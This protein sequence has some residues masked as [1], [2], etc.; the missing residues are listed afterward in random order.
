MDIEGDRRSEIGLR[1]KLSRGIKLCKL[2]GRFLARVNIVNYIVNYK[3]FA[4]ARDL[5]KSRACFFF[6][7]HN[8]VTLRALQLSTPTRSTRKHRQH[9]RY[10]PRPLQ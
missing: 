7:D 2:R 9:P 8:A 5:N 3:I 10:P 1:V 6:R 4:R